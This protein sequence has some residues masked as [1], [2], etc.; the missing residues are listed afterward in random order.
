M[1]GCWY[2]ANELGDLPLDDPWLIRR[3]ASDRTR[4]PAKLYEDSAW[5]QQSLNGH[6]RLPISDQ[7]ASRLLC[8][9]LTFCAACMARADK[10]ETRRK[11]QN[12][13]EIRT[14]IPQLSR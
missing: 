9:R 3:V 14:T 7:M 12:N 8:Q 10:R 13:P 1:H 11:R 5:M 4:C 6:L 2:L